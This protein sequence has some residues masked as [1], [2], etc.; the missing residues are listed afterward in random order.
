MVVD[1]GNMVSEL[2]IDLGTDAIFKINDYLSEN[3]Y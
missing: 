2:G 3:V 1:S